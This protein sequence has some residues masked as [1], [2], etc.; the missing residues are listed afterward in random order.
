MIEVA[1][2][3]LEFQC[4][5]D[6]TTIR[7]LTPTRANI[8]RTAILC[9]LLAKLLGVRHSPTIEKIDAQ[10]HGLLAAELALTQIRSFRDCAR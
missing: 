5:F 7:R 3:L 1:G 8:G 6:Q 10:I 9:G 4:Q 2:L